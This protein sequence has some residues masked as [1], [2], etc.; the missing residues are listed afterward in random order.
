ML[1]KEPFAE[2]GTDECDMV[3]DEVY[4]FVGQEAARDIPVRK[5][6]CGDEG[7]VGDTDS[8][9]DLIPFLQAAQDA[10]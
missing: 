10:Y 8:V 2:W 6:G 9:V 7:R 3:L 4:R 5:H 1:G